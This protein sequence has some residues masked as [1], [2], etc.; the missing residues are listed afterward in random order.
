LLGDVMHALAP[1]A[2][3]RE[4]DGVGEVFGLGGGARRSVQP[5]LIA[6]N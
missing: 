6:R 2:S 3:E 4:R 5:N 1:K